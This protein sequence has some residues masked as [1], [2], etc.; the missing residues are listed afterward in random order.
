MGLEEFFENN[1][2]Q[3][4][5]DRG[6]SFMDNDE[7]SRSSQ[8]PAS[9]D[10]DNFRLDVIIGKIRNNKKLKIFVIVTGLLI[11]TLLIVLIVVLFPL[12]VKLVNYIVQNGL[13]GI[14][15]EITG[16]LDKILNG[17]AS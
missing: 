15:K 1:N 8:Y 11:L 6:K 5:N 2:R 17:T 3:F 4:R 16:F 9:V 7:Y 10:R 12:I 13:Q 14:F